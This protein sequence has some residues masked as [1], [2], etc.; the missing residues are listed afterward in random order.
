MKCTLVVRWLAEYWWIQP[1]AHYQFWH[2][3]FGDYSPGRWGDVMTKKRERVRPKKVQLA[4]YLLEKSKDI[5]GVYG[6]D[7]GKITI[8]I[9]CIS[10]HFK[11]KY[12]KVTLRF[13]IQ[14]EIIFYSS[15]VCWNFQ[16]CDYIT[17]QYSNSSSFQ[18][19][20]IAKVWLSITNS[21]VNSHSASWFMM[22]S[23][24]LSWAAGRHIKNTVTQM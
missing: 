23:C 1:T 15:I 24:W 12:F 3:S 20:S 5:H 18:L 22:L 10:K 19:S 13:N 8:L 21:V 6:Q 7:L 16:K 11:Q 4:Q 9:T 14:V 17:T 2:P